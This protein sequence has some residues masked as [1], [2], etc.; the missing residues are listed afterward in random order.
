M[1]NLPLH[2]AVLE[3]LA[4]NVSKRLEAHRVKAGNGLPD[5]DYQRHV[6]RI[7]EGQAL[8]AEIEDLRKQLLRDE[9][10]FDDDDQPTG[11]KRV[12]ARQRRS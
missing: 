2:L 3:R 1:A 9:D 5:Q 7:A 4:S 8:A 12:K 6:G 11:D 10:M